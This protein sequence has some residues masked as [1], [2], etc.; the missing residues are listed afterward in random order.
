MSSRQYSEIA[1][2]GKNKVDRFGH[3]WSPRGNSRFAVPAGPFSGYVRFK[4]DG[5]IN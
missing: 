1:I 4:G 3:L 2:V 5:G